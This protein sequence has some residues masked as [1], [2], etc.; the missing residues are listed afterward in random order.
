MPEDFNLIKGLVMAWISVI[1]ISKHGLLGW[2]ICMSVMIFIEESYLP[3]SEREHC[4]LTLGGAALLE[5][6]YDEFCRK[7]FRLKRRFFHRAGLGDYPLQGR[8]L[9]NRRALES[10]RKMEF[11]LEL[12]SLVRL[13]ET[14]L[15]AITRRLVTPKPPLWTNLEAERGNLDDS[16][17]V[18]RIAAN[19]QLQLTYLIERV[20]AFML[21]CH[22]G[23][24]AKL[25]FKSASAAQD[26]QISAGCLELFYKSPY[27][28]GFQG[29]LGAAMFVPAALSP[30]MQ[31]ADLAAYLI[32]QHE[33]G[34]RDLRDLYAELEGMQFVS[35]LA[36]DEFEIKGFN[37]IE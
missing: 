22:P 35:S 30:G 34:R 37:V 17:T 5:S 14:K 12:F 25:V 7:F 27:G 21:E 28:S 32:N 1:W 23:K 20:N 3:A 18:S 29:V 11:T 19:Y 10:Y 26:Q 36:Q 6:R 33:S 9:L 31:I 13:L 24:K 4:L 2:G 15:F 16:A 8:R